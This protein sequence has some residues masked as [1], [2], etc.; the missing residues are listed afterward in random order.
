MTVMMMAL[1]PRA[2][3]VYMMACKNNTALYTGVTNDLARRVF[4]QKE[5]ARESFTHRYNLSQLVYYEE[6]GDARA[7][8]AREKQLKSGSRSSKEELVKGMNPGWMDLAPGLF[9]E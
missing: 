5:R 7:A 3:Y 9:G 8:I 2:M 4:E 1:R 6:H